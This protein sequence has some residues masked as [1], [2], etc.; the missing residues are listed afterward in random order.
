M[1]PVV[2]RRAPKLDFGSGQEVP[3]GLRRLQ[4]HEGPT[5]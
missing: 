2:E 5:P 1:G 4:G 3:E